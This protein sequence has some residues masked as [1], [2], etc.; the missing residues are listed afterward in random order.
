MHDLMTIYRIISTVLGWDNSKLKKRASQ[1]ES[2]KQAPKKEQL[3]ALKAYVDSTQEEQAQ[4]RS[5]SRTHSLFYRPL[6]P[7]FLKS[8]S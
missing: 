4:C 3:A 7:P 5:Q 2:N 1:I 6:S 8:T